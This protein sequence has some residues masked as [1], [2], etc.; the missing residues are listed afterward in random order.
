MTP[1]EDTRLQEIKLQVL[2]HG[3]T[4][5]SRN[6]MRWF[7]N[8]LCSDQILVP[9]RIVD[10]MRAAGISVAGLNIWKPLEVV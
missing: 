9:Q 2:T 6:D 3:V 7:V 10:S 8:M 1:E 4:G 5:V